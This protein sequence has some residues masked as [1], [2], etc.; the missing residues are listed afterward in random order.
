L[1]TIKNADNIIVLE[2]GV[3]VEEGD[4]ISLSK[5]DNGVFNKM[6]ALQKL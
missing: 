1:A 6:V 4:Y 5:K 2:S 3:I